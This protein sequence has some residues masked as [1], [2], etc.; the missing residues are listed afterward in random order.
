M[1]LLRIKLAHWAL[2]N[3]IWILCG[4]K[5]RCKKDDIFACVWSFQL[6]VSACDKIAWL[7]WKI[8]SVC[9]CWFQ[10]PWRIPASWSATT[11]STLCPTSVSGHS[12]LK[13]SAATECRNMTPSI[14]PP[15]ARTHVCMLSGIVGIFFPYLGRS[16]RSVRGFTSM[17]SSRL[18]VR[19]HAILPWHE[20]SHPHVFR[21]YPW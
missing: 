7:S 15:V 4:C 20:V 1:I 18:L 14:F 9:I 6:N 17:Y 16:I 12:M 8:I 10:G 11:G 13:V 5:S 19:M 2:C 3:W 21:N